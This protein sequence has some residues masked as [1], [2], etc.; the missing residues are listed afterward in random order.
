MK[1]IP[2]PSQPHVENEHQWS[3]NDCWLCILGN[4]GGNRLQTVLNKVLAAFIGKRECDM[5]PA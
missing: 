1:Q 3:I 5:L 2:I 4:V